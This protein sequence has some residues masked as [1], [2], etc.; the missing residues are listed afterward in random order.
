MWFMMSTVCLENDGAKLLQGGMHKTKTFD[1][2][3]YITFLSGR[4]LA[5]S[6]RRKLKSNQYGTN[7]NEVILYTDNTL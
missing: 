5:C 3:I 1:L 6:F 4:M 7:Y 2:M